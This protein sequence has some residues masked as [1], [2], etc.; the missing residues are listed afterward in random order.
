MVVVGLEFVVLEVKQEPGCDGIN[1]SIDIKKIVRHLTGTVVRND[2]NNNG[3][4]AS[5]VRG[6]GNN[7][8]DRG[9][10]RGSRREFYL[11]RV[12]WIFVT[13]TKEC[14]YCMVFVVI[15]FVKGME[16]SKKVV[17]IYV[18]SNNLEDILGI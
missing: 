4:N 12:N 5:A 10:I 3:Q 13:V 7:I 8:L 17:P 9:R 14:P 16:I 15:F 1:M 18:L 6:Y 2:T 11:F